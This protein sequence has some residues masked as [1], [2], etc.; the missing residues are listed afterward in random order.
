SP[1]SQPEQRS[2]MPEELRLAV[3]PQSGLVSDPIL[4]LYG[5]DGTGTLRKALM[6]AGHAAGARSFPTVPRG[7]CSWYHLGLAVTEADIARH[8]AFLAK[9]MPELAKTSTNG[10][11]PVIQVDDGW[12]PRWQRWGDWVANEFFADGLHALATRVHR[13][14]L[15]IGIWLA[16]FHV[17]ADS[18]LARAHPE[19][20]LRPAM[21]RCWLTPDSA[22]HTT[23][24]TRPIPMPC[25]SLTTSLWACA[26]TGS[27]TTSS[28]SSTAPLMRPVATIPR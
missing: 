5:D 26:E 3:P 25:D 2:G 7:W 18:Q 11:R 8:A 24:W 1:L 10:Y 28:T 12:M 20:L 27:P 15:E 13:H 4:L 17:A 22:S 9:R 23:S 14:R 21:V 19:W 16:P 6:A